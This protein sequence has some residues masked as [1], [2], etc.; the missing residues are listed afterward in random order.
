M[1]DNSYLL[2]LYGITTD[3]TSLIG[4]TTSATTTRKSQPTA[5]WA[6]T[7]LATA[8]KAS[9]LVRAALAGRKIINEGSVELDLSGASSDYRKM[10]AL[11]QGLNSLSALADRAGVKGL[12]A[13]EA[14]QVSKRFSEG[15]AEMSAYLKTADFEDVRLVQGVSQTT[16]KTGYAQERAPTTFT[17]APIHQGVA[18]SPVDAFQGDVKFSMTAKTATGSQTVSMDLSEMGSTE[19]SM[20]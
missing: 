1:I 5:P 17:T 18:T 20:V 11:Y 6:S 12:T 10:F 15:L 4:S 16:V 14:A 9:D 8:P 13:S 7:E 2:G 19:R 3:A